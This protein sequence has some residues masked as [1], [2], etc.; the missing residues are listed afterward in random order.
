MISLKT[1]AARITKLDVEVCHDE[2]CNPLYWGHKFK[3]RGRKSKSCVGPQMER[4]IAVCCIRKLHWVR[5]IAISVYV[6]LSVCLY[7]CISEK[8]LV[9]ISQNCTARCQASAVYAVVVSV[10]PSVCHKSGVLRRPLKMICKDF[11]TKLIK[12]SF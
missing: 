11:F 7:A 2:S 12:S 10:G 9:Q 4:N 3:G 8:P 5:N 6:C 1:D